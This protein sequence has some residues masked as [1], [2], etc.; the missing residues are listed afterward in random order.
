MHFRLLE[1]AQA[2]MNCNELCDSRR[3]LIGA[4]GV[5]ADGAVVVSRNS[6]V[7]GMARYP[8][9]HA[10]WKLSRKLTKNSEVYVA[11]VRR[12]G[13]LGMARPCHN[14]ER[15]LRSTGV[16]IVYYTISSTE[17]GIWNLQ[18]N[19]ERTVRKEARSV[20]ELSFLFDRNDES[21]VCDGRA[22]ACKQQQ[23]NRDE[24]ENCACDS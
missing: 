21:T 20:S 11:R 1:A 18:T 9:C 6:S 8:P 16:K 2:A 17:Y 19:V 14:C 12:I 4:V 13:D 5:R 10:E 3:M 7:M 24:G 15:V 22:R 23:S